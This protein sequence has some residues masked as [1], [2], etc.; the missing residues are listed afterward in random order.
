MFWEGPGGRGEMTKKERKDK[1]KN[2]KGKNN[3][4]NENHFLKKHVKTF[5]EYNVS[6]MNQMEK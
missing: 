5:F 2:G 3:E 1:K 6:K 4:N